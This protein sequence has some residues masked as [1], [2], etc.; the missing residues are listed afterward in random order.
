M[1]PT[2]PRIPR[3]WWGLEI[4]GRDT[5]VLDALHKSRPQALAFPPCCLVTRQASPESS[6]GSQ[7]STW[8]SWVGLGILLWYELLMKMSQ[9]EIHLWY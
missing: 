7:M 3:W 4:E 2:P 6:G 1:V 8:A 9:L 5:S